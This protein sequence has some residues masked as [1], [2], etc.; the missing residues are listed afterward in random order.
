[1]RFASENGAFQISNRLLVVIYA[2]LNA[3]ALKQTKPTPELENPEAN[4]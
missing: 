4:T 3:R 1:M 2:L